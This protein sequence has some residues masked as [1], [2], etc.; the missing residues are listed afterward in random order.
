M[1]KYI[2]CNLCGGEETKII[3]EDE[4]SYSVVKCKIC[5]LV[6]VNPQPTEEELASSYGKEYY[7]EWIEK[8]RNARVS[9]W[10][11][12]L[13]DLEKYKRRKSGEKSLV[14]LDVGCGSG[15]FLEIAKEVYEVYGTEISPF[16]VEY[17][18]KNLGI[19]VYMGNLAALGLP[20]DR[21]DIVTIWHT[22]EHMSEP[23]ENLKEA[24]RILKDNGLL[25]VEVPNLN[26]CIERIIYRIV[27]RKKMHLFS[28][29]DKEPH[30]FHFTPFTLKEILKRAGFQVIKCCPE[31][32][33]VFFKKKIVEYLGIIFYC[34]AGIN[35]GSTIR[36]YAIK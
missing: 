17:V 6:Y 33:Q 9:L 3:Q 16:A 5:G 31:I 10:S 19:E 23:L 1:P 8:Q 7:R 35:I 32:S 36:V 2:K 14:L 4:E 20:P 34:L 29:Y 22:L 12:R 28:I 18:K 26:A 11:K 21:Y 30:L 15:E 25:I 13:K 27:K 24:K